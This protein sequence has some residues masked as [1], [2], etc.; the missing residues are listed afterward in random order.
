MVLE[1]IISLR[2]DGPS[3]SHA[4]TITVVVGGMGLFTRVWESN[5]SGVAMSDTMMHI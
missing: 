3:S 2:D 1:V 4:A 5:L